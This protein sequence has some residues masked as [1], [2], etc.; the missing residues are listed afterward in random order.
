[1]VITSLALA[2]AAYVQAEANNTRAIVGTA[3]TA[4]AGGAKAR[5]KRDR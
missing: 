4:A 3:L 5:I 2:G 1:V